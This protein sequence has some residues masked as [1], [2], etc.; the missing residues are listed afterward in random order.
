[1]LLNRIVASFA[2]LAIF[3]SLSVSHAAKTASP[4]KSVCKKP[5]ND[6]EA[7]RSPMVRSVEPS[8]GHHR[9]GTRINIAGRNFQKGATVR[10]GGAP[11]IGVSVLDSERITCTTTSHEIGVVEVAII[12]K[13][14]LCGALPRSF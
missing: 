8:G 2:L 3:F 1:M 6:E 10:I 13:D 12:N 7:L 5:S 11:C 14:D 4:T 9:G